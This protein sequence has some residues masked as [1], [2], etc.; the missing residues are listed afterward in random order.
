MASFPWTTLWT[1]LAI[2]AACYVV[3]VLSVL[4]LIATGRRSFEVQEIR[5]TDEDDEGLP[6]AA[7]A[8]LARASA[9]L[10]AAGWPRLGWMVG[11]APGAWSAVHLARDDATISRNIIGAGDSSTRLTVFTDVCSVM[12]DGTMVGA[13]NAPSIPIETVG[14]FIYYWMPRCRSERA[15]VEAHAA[16][17]RGHGG[18][19]PV[20]P[21]EE[22]WL[23]RL[24]RLSDRALASGEQ[25]HA[26]TRPD[27]SGRRRARFGFVAAHTLLAQPGVRNIRRWVVARRVRASLDE[28]GVGRLW[29]TPPDPPGT[30]VGAA[31]LADTVGP[32]PDSDRGESP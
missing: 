13:V 2:I 3:S 24:R 10:E 25:D 9:A 5:L 15:L 32:D 20:P 17:A 23:D 12:R 1:A 8:A 6:P 7:K 27:E 11:A 19:E 22:A 14:S 31:P 26:L 18:T 28:A 16:L 29:R 21:G 30:P 4:A